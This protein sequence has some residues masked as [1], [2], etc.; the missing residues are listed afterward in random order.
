[1]RR[2]ILASVMLGLLSVC[3]A[4]ARA[5]EGTIVSTVNP[6]ATSIVT[7]DPGVAAPVA[8]VAPVRWY[9]GRPYGGWYGGYYPGYYYPG[10]YGTYSYSYPTY[11]YP[12]PVYPYR[13]YAYP[14]RAYRFGWW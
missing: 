4:S 8:P 7:T 5:D 14:W 10:Y 12:G 2:L 6:P 13:P 3:V 1:M 9:V 11:V